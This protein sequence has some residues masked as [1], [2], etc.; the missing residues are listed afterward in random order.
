MGQVRRDVRSP[1]GVTIKA[2]PCEPLRTGD[3]V[4]VRDPDDGLYKLVLWNDDFTNYTGYMEYYDVGIIVA[5]KASRYNADVTYAFVVAS[6]GM[7]A[8]DASELV[9]V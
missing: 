1:V 6:N 3:L 5:F 7:G 4:G 9:A 2:S 8:V